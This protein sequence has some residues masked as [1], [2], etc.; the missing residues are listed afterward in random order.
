MVMY[1]IELI[2]VSGEE[3]GSYPPQNIPLVLL[4]PEPKLYLA[5]VK[6]PKAVVFP[7]D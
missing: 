3:V 2:S 5:V 6:L 1:S 4:A 7:V